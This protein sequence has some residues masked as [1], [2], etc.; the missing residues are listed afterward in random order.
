MRVAR[1]KVNRRQ[2]R[3]QRAHDQRSRRMLFELNRQGGS[4]VEALIEEVD[5]SD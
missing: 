5:D 3:R 1:E 2:I 4:G